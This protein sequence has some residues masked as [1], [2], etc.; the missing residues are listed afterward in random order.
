[1]NTIL[2]SY[3][4]L[5]LSVQSPT[6]TT[7]TLP[8]PHNTNNTTTTT[9][10]IIV[11]YKYILNTHIQTKQTYSKHYHTIHNTLNTNNKQQHH[12]NTTTNNT[13]TTTNT[14]SHTSYYKISNTVTAFIQQYRSI[15]AMECLSL[16]Y[17]AEELQFVGEYISYNKH[18]CVDFISAVLFQSSSDSSSNSCSNSSGSNSSSSSNNANTINSTTTTTTTTTTTPSAIKPSKPTL[19]PN[20]SLLLL[21]DTNLILFINTHKTTTTTTIKPPKRELFQFS[22]NKQKIH[23]LLNI[24]EIKQKNNNNTIKIRYLLLQYL[25][26]TNITIKP[27]LNIRVFLKYSIKPYV[28]LGNVD[29][30]YMGKIKNSEYIEIYF[31]LLQYNDSS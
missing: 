22:Q 30:I 5:T 28:F 1:M 6:T 29:I 11:K 14:K 15:S 10:N 3:Y 13:T 12:N 26:N 9:T 19:K 24:N 31:K 18:D 8:P 4:D 23:Y 27:T 25:Y 2:D 17:K 16:Q 20:Q 21:N 7:T